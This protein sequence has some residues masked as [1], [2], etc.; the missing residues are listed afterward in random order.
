MTIRRAREEDLPEITRIYNYAVTNTTSTFDV[1]PKT[2]ED[3]RAWLAQHND[4]HPVLV[5]EVDGKVAGWGSLRQFGTRTAYRYSVEDA[6]YVDCDYQGRGIGKALLEQLL[7]LARENAYHAVLALVVG[8]NEASVR[9]HER[10]GFRLV[11]VMQEVG[12][13]FDTWLDVLIY[14]K[15][16]DGP[17]A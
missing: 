16:L 1:E 7:Q 2:L 6:V 14:E 15:L 3:R 11:G 9:L 8:G 17:G 5:A 12:R 4:D 10:F 13:K